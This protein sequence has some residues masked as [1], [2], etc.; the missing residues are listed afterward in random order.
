MR[1]LGFQQVWLNALYRLGLASGH[2]RRS[3]QPPKP[4]DGLRM[5]GLFNMPEAEIL[6]NTLGERGRQNLLEEADEI[7]N[8]KF[9]QFG[10]EPVVIILA[11]DGPLANWTDYETGKTGLHSDMED[12]KLTWEPARFGWAFVL[13]RAFRVTR[14]ERYADTFWRLFEGFMKGNPAYEGPNWISGQEVGLRLMA[15]IWAG[16][17]FSGSEVPSPGRLEKLTSAIA[18]H[19]AR[20]PGTLVYARSQNNNHLLTEAAAL[21]SCRSCCAGNSAPPAR[22]PRPPSSPSRRRCCT[23]AASRART[24]TRRSGR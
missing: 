5:R 24:S 23:T 4:I 19:A 7:V 15:W 11:P 18:V 13:G 12:I 22:S 20:I 21:C 10:A 2:Y 9:R 17:V 8:G 16:E 14:D 3:I 6:L 1:Q